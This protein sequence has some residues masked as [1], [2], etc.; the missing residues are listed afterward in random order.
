[1]NWI[2][3]ETI[4]SIL[5]RIKALESLSKDTE[6]TPNYKFAKKD[7]IKFLENMLKEIDQ[8]LVE[9]MEESERADEDYRSKRAEAYI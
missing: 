4:E 8:M 9:E 3:Q 7:E 5:N 2:L 1:M 6:V